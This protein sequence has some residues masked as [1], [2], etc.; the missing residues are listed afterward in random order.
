MND[1]RGMYVHMFAA[2]YSVFFHWYWFRLFVGLWG[3]T[4]ID[5][6]D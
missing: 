4:E 5:A 6:Y 2:Y 1:A 3:D